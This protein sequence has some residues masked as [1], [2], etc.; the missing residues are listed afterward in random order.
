[1]IRHHPS[2]GTGILVRAA[3]IFKAT[4]LLSGKVDSSPDCRL[5]GVSD[6]NDTLRFVN[7]QSEMDGLNGKSQ[8]CSSEAP[9]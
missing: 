4:R 8:I 9:E 3:N 6:L 5:H 1:M 2:S 7:G